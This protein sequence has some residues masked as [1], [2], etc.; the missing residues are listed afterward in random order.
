[1]MVAC[2]ARNGACLESLAKV[3][4]DGNLKGVKRL[5]ST[6]LNIH[7]LKIGETCLYDIPS[8]FGF[9]IAPNSFQQKM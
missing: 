3:V 4:E 5:N 6:P 2:I 9:H 1:M 8:L 7:Q